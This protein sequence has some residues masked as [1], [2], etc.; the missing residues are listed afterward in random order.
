MS[1]KCLNF[2]QRYPTAQSTC[3]TDDFDNTSEKL[4]KNRN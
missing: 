2:I 4:L 1:G 3:Q